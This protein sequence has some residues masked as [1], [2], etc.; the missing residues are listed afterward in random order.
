[1][2]SQYRQVHVIA[3]FLL[4][5]FIVV[6]NLPANLLIQQ[7]WQQTHVIILFALDEHLWSVVAAAAHPSYKYR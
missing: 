4:M 7:Q 3:V 1:M 2:G 5:L 6:N